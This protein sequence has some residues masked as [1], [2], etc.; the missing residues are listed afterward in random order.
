MPE[1]AESRP[2]WFEG[3]DEPHDTPVYA[4]DDLRPGMAFR[5]PAIVEQ[6]DTTTFVPPGVGAEVDRTGT[7]RMTISQED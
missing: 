1:P 6:L 7:I 4:R 5:G 2:V 3:R